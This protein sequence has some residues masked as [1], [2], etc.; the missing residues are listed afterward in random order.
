MNRGSDDPIGNMAITLV[1]LAMLGAVVSQ[2]KVNDDENLWDTVKT[3]ISHVFSEEQTTDTPPPPTNE[4]SPTN[5]G[6]SIADRLGFRV[7]K[8]DQ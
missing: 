6:E 5:E 1:G 4:P 2:I 7:P 3:G 8:G